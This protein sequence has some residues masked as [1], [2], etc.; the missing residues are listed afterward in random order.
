MEPFI[1]LS[2]GDLVNYL[3]G[4]DEL[5]ATAVEAFR[6]TCHAI[7]AV[8]HHQQRPVHVAVDQAYALLDPDRDRRLLG[9]LDAGATA[10]A[11]ERLTNVLDD[12]L[13][14]AH[15]APLSQAQIDAAVGVASEWG[16][17]LHVDFGMFEHLMVYSRGD[18]V[19]IRN[20]RRWNRLWREQPVEVP[21]YQ[22]AVVLFKLRP[23]CRT[24]DELQPEHV[25]LRMFKNI[26]KQD[27]DMLLPGTQV[28]IS[29]LD[30]TRILVPTLG[31]IGMTIWKIARMALLV[32]A[33]S[34]Y[35]A[36]VLAG[37][38]AAAVG[39][40]VRTVFSYMQTKNRYLL[41]L[42]RSLY[43][44]KLDSN[45]GVIYRLLQEA[46]QQDYCE[47]V[48]GYYA[49]WTAGEAISRRRWKRRAERILREA[50]QVEIDFHVDDALARLTAW[51][52][53]YDGQ[54]E[55]LQAVPPAQALERLDAWWDRTSLGN[56]PP[57]ETAPRA[58]S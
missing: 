10:D 30:Q 12:V 58:V 15:Y 42:T 38:I 55:R 27:V 4:R 3:I 21:I 37:L 51:E 36:A 16:V 9:A 43:Y 33:L 40:V 41:N 26:P 45:A 32:A 2:S 48:L 14:A 8:L 31:G 20:L 44:Q 5:Q 53:V 56:P 46:H 47:A 7:D 1:A 23:D 19:G 39:Y 18:I 22:R 6:T 52:L 50:L 29:W 28:R 13:R 57:T 54:A 25:H 49:L 35:T 17:P 34:F 11:A 24:E